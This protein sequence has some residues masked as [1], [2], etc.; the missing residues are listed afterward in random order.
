MKKLNIE[1]VEKSMKSFGLS[2]SDIAKRLNVSRESVSKWISNYNFPRPRH[3]LQLAEVLDLGF[4]EIVAEQKLESEP[5]IA[6]RKK[7]SHKIDEEYENNAKFKGEILK[8]LTPY[9]P[10]DTLSRPS[11]LLNP[12]NAYKYIQTVVDNIRFKILNINIA[13]VLEFKDLIESF[14]ARNSVI[15]PVQWGKKTDH[16]NALHIYLPDSMTTWIYLNLDSKIFDFKFWMAHEL[17]HIISP[18]LREDEAENFADSFAGALLFPKELASHEYNKLKMILDIGYKINYIKD[19]AIKYVVSPITIFREINNFA[20]YNGKK[21]IELNDEFQ[22]YQTTSNLNKNYKLVSD[23]LFESK[24]ISPNSYISVLTNEFKTPIFS[25]LKT[26]IKKNKSS[27][28]LIQNLFDMPY[29]DAASLFAE[30]SNT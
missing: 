2:Q 4:N 23:Y 1:N 25:I 21:P 18:D 15:I 5:I 12:K 8:K 13:T 9:L 19:L 16:A 20:Q 6:F 29:P 10:F 24:I 17:G 11:S 26:Y 27:T 14:Q 28:A 7:R 3:L 30:L 22:I